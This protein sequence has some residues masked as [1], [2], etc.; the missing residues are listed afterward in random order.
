M[1]DDKALK[2]D[3][4]KIVSTKFDWNILVKKIAVGV[5]IAVALAY[6]GPT[7]G[8]IVEPLQAILLA[9]IT[10]TANDI[11]SWLGLKNS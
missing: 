4:V 2:D 9:V 6:G 3:N 1:K 11:Q 7:V 5:L 10:S 8:L